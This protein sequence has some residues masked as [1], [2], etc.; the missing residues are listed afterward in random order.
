VGHSKEREPACESECRL[1][2]T[3][4]ELFPLYAPSFLPFLS[5]YILTFSLSSLP[6]L[7]L[8]LPFFSSLPTPPDCVIYYILIHLLHNLL[9]T[10]FT[11]LHN[12]TR[13][14]G[15]G[16]RGACG[17]PRYYPSKTRWFLSFSCTTYFTSYFT[18]YLQRT[19]GRFQAS[20]ASVSTMPT[21]A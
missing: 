14:D 4:T 1:E 18:K 21:Q 3:R 17:Q 10:A 13:C 20:H 12:Q 8:F 6:S 9:H 2:F 7:P 15:Q 19:R 11:Q 16:D 5:P